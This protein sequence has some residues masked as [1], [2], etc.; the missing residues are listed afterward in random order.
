MI[1]REVNNQYIDALQ[2]RTYYEVRFPL[3]NRGKSGSVRVCYA[4]FEEHEVTYLIT[5]FTKNEKENLSKEEKNVLR[6]LVKALK[7]E[8]AANRR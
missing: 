5:A 3:E 1:V 6:K 4:D 2:C 8:A 7:D